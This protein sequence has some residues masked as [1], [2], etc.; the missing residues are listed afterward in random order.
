MLDT[1]FAT[2][3]GM[4]QAWSQDGKR[5]AVTKCKVADV[6]V[7]GERQTMAVEKTRQHSERKAVRILELGYGEKKL[8]NVPK[9]LRSRLEKSGFSVGVQKVVG[10]RN[11]GELTPAADSTDTSVLKVGQKVAINQVLTVG[12]VVTVQGTT[13]G[14]GF[15]GV[16]KR[17]GFAGGPATHGQ[18]DR[19]RAVGSIGNRTT[20]GRVFKNKRM[21]GH[22]GDI[23]MTVQGLV[24]L[25][26]DANNQEVWLSG[27]IPGAI[28]GLVKITKTGEQKKVALNT[29]Q[30]GVQVAAA[31]EPVAEV[32]SEEPTVETPEVVS[33]PEGTTEEAA[34]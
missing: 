1:I 33:A 30:A 13:K 15:T 26:I 16:V 32:V 8:K 25:H 2:K 23:T 10:V 7:V 6:L 27:P 9:P 18:S 3:L 11:F 20:P 28:S 29:A 5:L 34:A 31:E 4:T 24:V 12:D 17:Y 19:E 14:R 21:H 22:S